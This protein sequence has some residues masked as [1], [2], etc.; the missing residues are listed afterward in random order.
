MEMI[1]QVRAVLFDLDGVLL[2]SMPSYR[3]AW[4][5]WCTVRG[6]DVRRILEAGS[7]RRPLDI[8][9]DVAP[10]L[11]AV[12]E[13]EFLVQLLE[14]EEHACRAMPGSATL[15]AQLPKSGWA[16]VTSGQ[17]DQ[18]FA[19]LRRLG[20]P[21]PAHLVAGEDVAA[22]KP[23][24]DGY[25]EAARLLG[26]LPAQCLVVEDAPAGVRA[27]LAAGARVL[28]LATTHP[29]ADLAA[30]SEVEDSLE[31]AAQSVLKWLGCV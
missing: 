7:G 14:E 24:P 16:V 6:T 27:G 1:A 20:L 17:R 8:L 5:R 28:A 13:E 4:Q 31:R 30:A 2:D 9:A 19:R 10:H 26:V 18:T 23:A 25:L 3:R 11:D 12:R 21:A 15:L 29:R 22:G